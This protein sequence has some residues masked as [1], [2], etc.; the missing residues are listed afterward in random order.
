MKNSFKI[1]FL[2][3]ALAIAVF[4]CGDDKNEPNDPNDPN[5]PPKKGDVY[6]AGYEYNEQGKNVATVWKNGVAHNL[7]DGTYYSVAL[8]V[9]VSGND[10][11]VAGCDYTGYLG[12]SGRWLSIAKLWKNGIAQNLTDGTTPANATSVYVSGSDVYVAGYEYEYDGDVPVAKLW[13]NGI[14]QNLTTDGTNYAAAHSV[15]VSGSD[16][17]VAGYEE[18]YSRATL[19]KNGEKQ[20]LTVPEGLDPAFEKAYSVFVS[21][22]DVYVAGRYRPCSYCYLS[23]ALWKNGSI[24][25]N[26]S[27]IEFYSV[28]VSGSDIYLAGVCAKQQAWLVKIH[29]VNEKISLPDGIFANSVFVVE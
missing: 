29:P 7:S 4:S 8:S 18:Y 25:E 11:Y 9:F 5:A 17:Y 15:Y 1:S 3:A 6:V 13:K 22:N 2:T 24:V 26:N 14:A 16:V 28:F 21:N 23:G 27:G 20:Y 19:W 12:G 10:V